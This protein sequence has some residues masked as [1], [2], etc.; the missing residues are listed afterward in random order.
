M[1]DVLLPTRSVKL[2]FQLAFTSVQARKTLSKHIQGDIYF[3]TDAQRV[4]IRSSQVQFYG[5]RGQQINGYH[6]IRIQSPRVQISTGRKR[7][8]NL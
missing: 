1:I 4:E 2:N 5:S 3:L 7:H 6:V 8:K